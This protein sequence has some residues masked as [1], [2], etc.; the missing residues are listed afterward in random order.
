MNTPAL[1]KPKNVDDINL[2][3]LELVSLQ[4]VSKILGRSPKTIWVWWAKEQTFPK[5]IM[6]NG[7][8]MGWRKKALLD[9]INNL[10]AQS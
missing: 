5:P 3:D 6:F 2:A 10:E 7:R 1:Q 4:Q 8:C 9:W